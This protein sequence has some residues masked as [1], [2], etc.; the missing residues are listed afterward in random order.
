MD[1][2]MEQ[3]FVVRRFGALRLGVLTLPLGVVL[4]A[5]APVDLLGLSAATSEV[6]IVVGGVIGFAVCAAAYRGY[7]GYGTVVPH[8]SAARL[9]VVLTLVMLGLGLAGQYAAIALGLRPGVA[10]LVFAVA[11]GVLALVQRF[12]YGAWLPSEAAVPV[13][14]GA[15][16]LAVLA[17]APP[18]EL[19]NG[20]FTATLGAGFAV[21][22][23]L[24]HLRLARALPPVASTHD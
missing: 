1:A 8:R 9:D 15:G 16:G 18:Q 6:L 4:L 24:N 10:S 3:R 7:R 19:Q 14:V 17:L 11:Y 2:I 22:A 5:S 21:G 12:R 20:I 23:L 13:I